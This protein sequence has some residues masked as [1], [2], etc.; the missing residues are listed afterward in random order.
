MRKLK[1]SDCY[2]YVSKNPDQDFG[3]HWIMVCPKTYFDKYG[4]CY[5]QHLG[6]GLL[7][8]DYFEDMECTFSSEGKD[9]QT[10]IQE[11]LA[12]GF[13]QSAAF[14]AFGAQGDIT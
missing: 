14:D 8:P 10:I 2:F 5:D 7:P 11:L 4:Y 12:A 13:V 1:P 3:E 9:K 6:D